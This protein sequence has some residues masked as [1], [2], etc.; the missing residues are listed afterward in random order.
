VA[1]LQNS[2]PSYQEYGG[3]GA[4]VFALQAPF[5]FG[6]EALFFDKIVLIFFL[7]FLMTAIATRALKLAPE[8][9]LALVVMVL[10]AVAVP[11]WLNGSWLAD[12]RLPVALPFVLVAITRLD[13]TRFRAAGWFAAVALVL[14]GV[15]VWAVSE[16]WRDTDRL[17][18]EFRSASQVISPGARL[19]IVGDAAKDGRPLRGVSSFVTQQWDETFAHM[20]ALAVM[21]RA[22]FI[23]YLFSGWTSV[24]PAA[25]NAGLFQTQAA[26]LTSAALR[27]SATVEPG[28][29]TFDRLDFLGERP[30][31]GNWPQ[32]FDFVLWIDFRSMPAPD[33]A[34]LQPLAQGS[35]FRIYRVAPPS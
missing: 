10:A 7:V 22:A 24:A 34:A 23:P 5:T 3:L 2:G 12:I 4:K 30:Y 15:R 29:G 16:Y 18:A 8:M 1:S 6:P 14:L 33:L 19:L 26:P 35:F 11:N 28:N 25:R 20:P 9:R 17:F 31:W 32:H 13:A 27:Q 21:D